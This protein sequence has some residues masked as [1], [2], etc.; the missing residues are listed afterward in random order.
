MDGKPLPNAGDGGY[1]NGYRRGRN[2]DNTFHRV[3]L[4][5]HTR[6]AAF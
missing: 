6:G 4:S 2:Q 3:Q 1:G 5:D